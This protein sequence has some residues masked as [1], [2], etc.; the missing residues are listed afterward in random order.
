[1]PGTVA[2]GLGNPLMGDDGIGLAMLA[3]ITDRWQCEGVTFV[4]G[5]TWGLSLLPEIEDADRLVLMDA[6]ATGAAAGDVVRLPKSGLPIYLAK[7]LS[8]HQVDLKDALALAEWRGCLTDDV[9]AIGIQPCVVELRT[10][11]SPAAAAS[12]DGAVAAVIAQLRSWGHDC[13]PAREPVH[14]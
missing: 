5:G 4:D 1:M 2:I 10:D 14:A 3:A 9:V 7:R 11:L 12:L 13:V 6:I 8:P